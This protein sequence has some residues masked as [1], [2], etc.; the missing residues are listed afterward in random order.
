LNIK[1]DHFIFFT[2]DMLH[3]YNLALRTLQL[4]S[5]SG[6]KYSRTIEVSYNN[7]QY[8]FKISDI[9]IEI[10]FELLGV[11]EMNIFQ[12]TFNHI[13]ETLLYKKDFF[14]I[15]CVNFNQIKKELLNIFYSFMG[16]NKLRFIFITDKISFINDSIISKAKIYRCESNNITKYPNNDITKLDHFPLFE[17]N[18][19]NLIKVITKEYKR[20]DVIHYIRDN[21]Y[22]I[23]I[24]NCNIYEMINEIIG[25]L[26]KINY[27]TSNNIMVVMKEVTHI[28]EKFNNNYRSIFHLEH[29][30]VYL[31]NINNDNN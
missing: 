7:N 12:E 27:L 14:I 22:N 3:G 31:M 18:K 26:V 4:H 30:I 20:D 13:R 5:Q 9:H 29:L 17:D 11:N 16:Y 10:D 21:L 8:F 25:D 19:K 15:L 23:L 28:L 1:Q 24:R 2:Y 6:L